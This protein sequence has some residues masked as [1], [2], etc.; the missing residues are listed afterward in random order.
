MWM[1]ILLFFEFARFAFEKRQKLSI[2][3]FYVFGQTIRKIVQ[4]SRIFPESRR[5]SQ[6]T[7][8]SYVYFQ[9]LIE[10]TAN[11]ID[12][13][14]TDVGW[15]NCGVYIVSLKFIVNER[16]VTRCH[17]MNKQRQVVLVPFSSI[18]L[19]QLLC[20][21]LP[22]DCTTHSANNID[23]SGYESNVYSRKDRITFSF[24]KRR[25]D[26]DELTF[27]RLLVSKPFPTSNNFPFD[28]GIIESF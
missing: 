15:A 3:Q 21:S 6:F 13:K 8:F 14:L 16:A 26:C 12:Y 5:K 1:K 20:L 10:R 2:S 17:S 7:Y 22:V 4:T 28:V 27:K 23:T 18:R 24:K 11:L 9:F 25:D 19:I